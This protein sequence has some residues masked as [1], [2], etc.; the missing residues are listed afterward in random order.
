MLPYF[1]R[2]YHHSYGKWGRPTIYLA[3]MMQLPKPVLDE[4]Q[5]GNFV[6]KRSQRMFSQVDVDHGQEWSSRTEKTGVGIVG[7]TKTNSA[8]SS[9][10]LSSSMSCQKTYTLN[11]F[12]TYVPELGSITINDYDYGY[13][14]MS[15]LFIDLDYDYDYLSL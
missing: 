1:M 10:A 5:Q 14:Y 7:I 12:T 3:D 15:F 11:A 9:W 13:D 2:Y 8:L 4:F 6:V